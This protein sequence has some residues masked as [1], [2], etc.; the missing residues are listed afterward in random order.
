[1]YVVAIRAGSRLRFL[2]GERLRVEV[3][4]GDHKANLTFQTRYCEEG[5]QSLVPRELWID[6]RG[7]AESLDVAVVSFTN[8]ASFFATV[9]SF[10]ANGHVCDCAFHSNLDSANHQLPNIQSKFNQPT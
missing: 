1:M 5:Y 10:C 3:N 9:I 2:P 4:I 8:V 7:S 6:A